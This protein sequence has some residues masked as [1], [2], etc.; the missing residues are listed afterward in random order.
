MKRPK[1]P[2]LSSCEREPITRLDRVQAFGFLLAV[3]NDWLVS[4]ASEN[5]SEFLPR[6]A[7]AAIG[8]SVEQLNGKGAR[9]GA[10]VWAN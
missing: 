7:E 2:D 10:W 5:L 9:S 6:S 4:R 8:G 1:A 3:T